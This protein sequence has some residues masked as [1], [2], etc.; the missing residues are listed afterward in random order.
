MAVPKRRQS[1]S[2]SA[3]RRAQ[4]MKKPV[5]NFVPCPA[6][7]R[8]E[9]HAPDVRGL[10]LLPRPAGDR[11]EGRRAGLTRRGRRGRRSP[12]EAAAHAAHCRRRHGLRR[13][14]SGRGRGRR[15]RRARAAR[16]RRAPGRR[17]GPP[18]R[19]A[20]RRWAA[21]DARIAVRHAPEV[22][23]MHDAPSMAVKQKK[24][25]S[26]RV[27]FDLVKAGEADAVVSAGNSGAMMACGLFVLGRLP[28]VE[29]P[30][31]V[32]TFP[33]RPAS[34][35]CS[36]WAPTSIPSRRCWR[37][38]ACSARSTR[39]SCTA[40][41]AP[42]SGLL[43]NGSEE[44][45]GTPLTRD[46]HQMLARVAARAT[47]TSATSAT[48]RGATSSRGEVDVVVT[49]GFT[50]NVRPQVR[51]GRGGGDAGHGQGGGHAL[52]A[53]RQDRRRADDQRAQA[54]A[55]ADRLRR[56]RRR[57]AAGRRR[58][59]A[60]LPRRLERHGHARTPSTS[61]IASRRSASARSWRRRS[62][63][64][65]FSAEAAPAAAPGAEAHPVIA[66]PHRRH[67]P[68]RAAQGADQRR[69][70]ARWS[71]PRTPGSSS[72][73]ASA[74]ATSS[75]RRWPPAISATEA[76]RAAPAATRG[77]RSVGRRLHHRRHRHGRLSV[78]RHRHLRAE[79][80][81]RRGRAAARSISRPPAPASSTAS[82]S[83]TPSCGVGQFKNV[84]VI[85]VEVL[86]RIIDWTDRSTC[87]LFGDGAGAVL[88]D[89]RR[90]AVAGRGILSTHLFAD[91]GLAE[92]LWQPAGGSRE[93]TTPEALAAKRQFVQMNGREVYK[94][95]VR[96]MAA[97]ARTALEANGL[98]AGRRRLGDRPPGE[99]PHPRG[100]LRAR[101][102]PDDA[103]L[104]QRRSLRQ[105]LVGLGADRA[106]RG[107]R[108]GEAQDG[109][110][111]AVRGAGRRSRLGLGGG[112]VVAVSAPALAF[113]FPGQGSQKVGMG[114]ALAR[115]ASRRRARSSPRPTPRSASRSRKL[116]FEGP[117]EE[118][119]LTAN[120]QPAILT[121]SIAALRVLEAAHG[122]CA[123]RR[124]RAL[125]RRVQRAG[126][127]RARSRFADAVR[128]STCAASSCRRR[129][130]PGVGAMAAI[131]GPR[132]GRR[133]RRRLRARRPAA[134][135]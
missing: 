119:T 91:G 65:R 18:A 49:D 43:S 24:K 74:S 101:R 64:T 93:P 100:R 62:R 58:R 66:Q 25:S 38:S 90:R 52:G 109:R 28:G 82:R 133:G 46:A 10:R 32:T 11:A 67:R 117:E 72:A 37:S 75:T 48:S 69:P 36:T 29:R 112:E 56:A 129:S 41:R 26:M 114:R 20:R 5:P 122:A 54:A 126:R 4:V 104:H 30:A 7:R 131:L 124:R 127:G 70:V 9:A 15:G 121:V 33:T 50:G 19:R 61:P 12:R 97:G 128:L 83:P 115:G 88:H 125:A 22:I 105:H 123:R 84:L 118:L 51:R 3:I 134:R 80:A 34:A 110:P 79:E 120:A 8:A 57:A 135:W 14:A 60:H 21:E 6:L 78:P 59:G 27:C 87:V 85:G 13:R 44:H 53:A 108:A 132:R 23:T 81:G 39:A 71:T 96:N 63:A 86:S 92:I 103:L 76:G 106:R 116:C 94:H 68:R 1:K 113:L 17:R 35:R 40:R 47:P 73:P 111:A 55:Q 77:R 95:A 2:R 45:K 130:R 107:D 102:H 98:D 31:I 16:D 42:R 89:R 99:P